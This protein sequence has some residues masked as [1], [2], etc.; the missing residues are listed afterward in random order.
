MKKT[1]GITKRSAAMTLAI[2]LGCMVLSG[3]QYESVDDYLRAL[4]I[5][6][7][8]E[9]SENIFEE[10]SVDDIVVVG[11]DFPAALQSEPV[12]ESSTP[13]DNAAS[14]ELSFDSGVLESAKA[15]SGEH[16]NLPSEESPASVSTAPADAKIK[17][18]YKKAT[19]TDIDEDMKA[20]RVAIGLTDEGI[21]TLKN[22]QAGLYA[23]ERLTDSGKTLYVEILTILNTL[24]KDIIVSTTS[25]EAIELVFEYVMAD[26]P[27]IFYVDGYQFTNYSIGNTITK[28]SFTGNYLYS[29][30]E[31]NRRQAQINEAVG[32]CLATAPAS[33]D[34]Y[35]IIKYVYEYLISNTDYDT[36]A[37]DNQNI[38]SVFIN[39]RSVCNGYA[40]AAQ[41]LLN[42][43][44]IKSTLVTGTVNT[45]TAKGIRHA[46]NLVLCNNTYYYLDVTWGDASYQTV[47]GESADTTKLPEVN[48]DY[49]N[50]STSEITRNHTISDVISMPVC[51]SMADNYYVREDEYFTVPELALV[52]DLFSR[53]YSEGST[54]VTIKCASD[55]VYD[56]LFQGLIT[57]RKVFDYLQGDTSQISYTTFEDT[58]TIIFWL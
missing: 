2:A 44:G 1:R 16:P 5:K 19:D 11:N 49:L 29:V 31:V 58:R 10:A 34:D 40:K 25:D 7:P 48:Y 39:G 3:C 54:N 41:Y 47:S 32:R 46:W 52:G 33:E 35:Y 30:S 36:D 14:A 8:V 56:D 28:I 6:D 17:N 23:Y 37:P 38:C 26:H 51:T 57:E 12:Q 43:L 27:E 50:V 9:Y 18:G 53:R 4:G 55:K 13:L 20:K 24:S 15:A 42:K 22:K 45:K 21:A